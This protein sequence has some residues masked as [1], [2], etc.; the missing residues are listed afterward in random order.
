MKMINCDLH[1]HTK[2]SDD[3]Q[4]LMENHCLKAIESGV[5]FLCI[6]DHVDCNAID[7]GFDFYDVESFF[8]EF[9]HLKAKYQGQLTLLAGIEFG[10]PHIYQTQ[11]EILTK[12]PYDLILGSVHFWYQDLYASKLVNN[13]MSIEESYQRYYQ[14]LLKVVQ[15][16]KVDVV[17]HFDFPKRYY[18]KNVIH[19]ELI[20]TICRTM[21]EN[22]I[23]MEI[24][25]SSL[26]R[27][28]TETMPDREI[29]ILYKECGGKYVTIGSDAHI[30]VDLGAGLAYAKNLIKVMELE[31]VVFINREMVL[32]SNL[33]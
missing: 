10:E 29:L 8:K 5:S 16:N 7:S 4:E 18:H 12:H 15:D 32:L 3:S 26:R 33:K 2:Y 21:V 31:E 24:N 13:P 25:T 20:R 28:K 14:E 1:T 9:S 17:A 6:T 11:M 22:G 23:V 30:A 27:N 19:E